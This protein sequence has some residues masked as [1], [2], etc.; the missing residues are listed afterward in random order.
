M[1]YQ[2]PKFTREEVLEM[3]RRYNMHS[4]SAQNSLKNVIPVEKSEGI[5]FYDYNGKKYYDMSSQLV[6]MNIGHHNQDVIDAMKQQ[7]EQLAFIAPG[8]AVGVRAALAKKIVELA[9]EGMSRVFFCNG[10]ADSN[11]NAIKM[12]RMVTGRPKVLAMYR[13]YHGA[14]I[15]AGNVSGDW[16]RFSSEIG[17]SAPGVFH[18]FGPFK[19]REFIDFK[20]DEELTKYYLEM[21]EKQIIA[22]GV[23]LVAAIIVESVVGA[24]GVIIPPDGYMQGIRALCDKYGIMMICDEV[25][26]G[27]GRTGKW[28]AIQNWDVC[29]DM[30]TFAKGVNS[31]YVQLGGVIMTEKVASYFDDHVLGCGLTYQGH[32]MGCAAGLANL[33]WLEEHN[34]LDNVNKVG[35]VL[36]EILEEMKAKHACVGDVRY[37]GLFSAIDLVY[38]KKTRQPIADYATDT[39]GNQKKVIAKLKEKGFYTYGRDNVVQVCPPLIITEEELREAMKIMDEVLTWADEQ[40]CK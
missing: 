32:P 26:A 19:Y 15:T 33:N 14:T 40:F 4:W 8:Q 29:P 20:S 11:E 17:G 27:F 1:G 13:S 5:Y 18:F 34:T 10:G 16:R 12:A 7:A 24:N 6:N 2:L 38:D 30:I 3:D 37:I 35:K 25:M 31:G 21:L 36:G 28:F 23:N 39:T 22:E 9:P